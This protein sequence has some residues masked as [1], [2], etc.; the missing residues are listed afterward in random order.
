[1]G[2][3][4]GMRLG[5]CIR[6][7]GGHN[8]TE[9]P[10]SQTQ[11][12][13]LCDP[14][15]TELKANEFIIY[16]CDPLATVV[17]SSLLR[18]PVESWCLSVGKGAADPEE[19]RSPR[20][21]FPWSLCRPELLRRLRPGEPPEEGAGFERWGLPLSREVMRSWL[22]TKLCGAGHHCQQLGL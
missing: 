4:P 11:V 10:I 16:I 14:G 2:R 5:V 18:F 1:M 21:S 12:D 20:L 8:C 15:F 17:A 9:P 13:T 6:M 22:A 19:P 3:S 7:T